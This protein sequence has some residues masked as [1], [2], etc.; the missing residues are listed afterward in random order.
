MKKVLSLFLTLSLLASLLGGPTQLNGRVEFNYTINPDFSLA[1]SNW[2]P[3]DNAAYL[4]VTSGGAV[5][6]ID[7]KYSA[8]NITSMYVNELFIPWKASSELT[9]FFGYRNVADYD[10]FMGNGGSFKWEYNGTGILWY[11]S[12][13]S[14][15]YTW[16]GFTFD[17]GT[18]FGNPLTFAVLMRTANFYPLGLTLNVT[19]KADFTE[20]LI[21]ARL[22][23]P[24]KPFT[25]Y[26]AG[27]FDYVNS[28]AE[29][30]LFG[31]IGE[32]AGTRISAEVDLTKV[33]SDVT[34][35]KVAA[36]VSYKLV[37]YTV[38]VSG[39]YAVK[40]G[41]FAVEPYISTKLGNANAR[42]FARF[43][44]A[45]YKYLRLSVGYNF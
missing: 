3:G 15:I 7:V 9:V 41:A 33:L 12:L 8:P 27:G 19:G 26:F 39:N 29:G 43:E 44:N 13:I 36:D 6:V 22:S 31:L 32:L 16:N 23:Y 25:L 30:L 21:G 5:L 24:I 38:G 11:K 18:N 10:S 4:V 17:V 14:F 20:G 45:G 42:V 34:D 28:D 2:F 1:V 40:T 35:V 37:D